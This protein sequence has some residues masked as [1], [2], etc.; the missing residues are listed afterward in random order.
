MLD[1]ILII[2]LIL[3]ILGL[4]FLFFT[5]TRKRKI[6]IEPIPVSFKALL[7]EQVPFYQNLPD[8]GKQEFENRVQHFLATTRITGVNTNVED[9]D[10]VL[11]ALSAV[12]PI[13]NFAGW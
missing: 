13:F 7:A 1:V 2:I 9:I 11:I 5:R 6:V 8:D 12:I 3:A 4:L 10:R